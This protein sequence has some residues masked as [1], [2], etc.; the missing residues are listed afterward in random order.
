MQI[1][2]LLDYR[3]VLAK[4]ESTINLLLSLQGP[5]LPEQDR[6]NPLRI[7]ALLDRSPS[8]AGH[9]NSSSTRFSAGWGGDGEG[10][11]KMERLKATMMKLVD[12]LTDQDEL[13]M[14][15]FDSL[16]STTGIHKMTAS[17]RKKAKDE[18]ECVRPQG[19]TNIAAAIDMAKHLLKDHKEEAGVLT[20]IM[21]L[22]D[23]Q[24]TSGE[25]SDE[26]IVT[27]VGSLPHFAGLSCF[28]YGRDWNE[29]LLSAMSQRGGG[30]YYFIDNVKMVSRAFATEIGGLLTC[31]AKDIVFK[32][33][34]ASGV[35]FDRLLNEYDHEV[36]NR[37]LSIKAGD[38]FFEEDRKLVV[39]LKIDPKEGIG[40][41]TAKAAN[42]VEIATEYS[43]LVEGKKVQSPSV[44]IEV[45][46][47]Q[48]KDD[49]PTKADI[50]VAEEVAVLEAAIAQSEAKKKADAGDL[51]A[52]RKIMKG[53]IE[54]LQSFG[55]NSYASAYCA[56]M[57]DNLEGLNESYCSSSIV[58]KSMSSSSA[59]AT[60]S[61]RGIVGASANADKLFKMNSTKSVDDAVKSFEDGDDK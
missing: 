28:G 27:R 17:N 54:V 36:T 60:R 19:S 2:P 48:D 14:V 52:A 5:K 3:K 55:E 49:L 58:S 25:C 59:Y 44:K 31:Y 46:L 39:R 41:Q 43:S 40:F 22:T 32:L 6:R 47:V 51:E 26:A 53:S 8:M 34:L 33:A 15:W 56:V 11:T 1:T 21:L 35:K 18:I 20:R 45:E 30:G 24:P 23:G 38:L 13:A 12:N 50:V 42:L 29:N 37:V 7:I 57:H 10:E 9:C 4:G 61:K 16:V